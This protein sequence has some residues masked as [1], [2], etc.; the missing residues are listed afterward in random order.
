MRLTPPAADRGEIA[1]RASGL[2]ALTL[3]ACLF[4]ASGCGLVPD[5][6]GDEK[7]QCYLSMKLADESVTG[8]ASTT[9]TAVLYEAPMRCLMFMAEVD[10]II[11]DEG[12][13]G[14]D[15]L[16]SIPHE[17]FI[18]TAQIRSGDL[19]ISVDINDVPGDFYRAFHE[20]STASAG[21][22]FGDDVDLTIVF[23]K[24]NRYAG[25]RFKP[26]ARIDLFMSP[27]PITQLPD[28]ATQASN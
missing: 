27:V 28:A 5:L 9:T 21:F 25:G 4:L 24:D 16:I 23:K 17:G 7:N 2:T 14:L 26:P 8:S 15:Y 3:S 1:A 10:R 22:R 18:Q 11:S 20:Q 13:F 12:S 19:S 6:T